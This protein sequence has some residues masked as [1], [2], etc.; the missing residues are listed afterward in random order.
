[1]N[2]PNNGQNAKI[3]TFLPLRPGQSGYVSGKM[4][5]D[6]SCDY[7]VL[8]DEEVIFPDPYLEVVH[9]IRNLREV[10]TLT[11]LLCT[12]GGWVETGVDIIH[13]IANTKGT[14]I[15]HAIGMCASIGA[16]IWC[17]GK[18]RKISPLAT[19]MFH[20]PSGGYFG[21]SL[22]VRDETTQLCEYFRNLLQQISKGILTEQD[23][24]M[25]VG[26]R[27]DVFLSGTTVQQ[28]LAAIEQANTQT[29]KE[30]THEA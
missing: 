15:T 16:V 7:T 8:L 3:A 18:I 22:D 29:Q 24:E 23:I 30:P 1:M 9:T 19:L 17:C 2:E 28:R 13:A 20:M 25:V 12:N 21:K 26:Q 27:K 11:I 4:K 5:E 14:V 10:D 6:G